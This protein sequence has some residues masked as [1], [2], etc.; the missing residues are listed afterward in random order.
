MG[1]S[2]AE[3]DSRGVVWHNPLVNRAMMA[4]H[5]NCLIR[6]GFVR[7]LASYSRDVIQ[8]FFVSQDKIKMAQCHNWGSQTFTTDVICSTESH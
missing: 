7:P 8:F 3:D 5:G 2:Q 4:H 1:S 6:D